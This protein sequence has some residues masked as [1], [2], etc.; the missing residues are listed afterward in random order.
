MSDV[1]TCRW[2]PLNSFDLDMT[3]AG[4]LAR[5]SNL[6]DNPLT[7][8][9]IARAQHRL[10]G[11]PTFY[12]VHVEGESRVNTLAQD[13]TSNSWTQA[14]EKRHLKEAASTSSTTDSNGIV[15]PLW[16]APS[17][18]PWIQSTDTSYTEQFD[19]NG[20]AT[21][22][23]VPLPTTFQEP[24]ISNMS[25]STTPSSNS[26]EVT[27]NSTTTT[28]STYEI[29]K[30][31]FFRLVAE[32]EGYYEKYLAKQLA[33]STSIFSRINNTL[34]GVAAGRSTGASGYTA[35]EVSVFSTRYL[36][37]HHPGFPFMITSFNATT[38]STTTTTPASSSGSSPVAAP[39]LANTSS[40]ATN[41]NVT[42]SSTVVGTTNGN[43]TNSSTVVGSSSTSTT[44]NTDTSNT[45][46]ST[47][48]SNSTGASNS[49]NTTTNSSGN[50]SSTRVIRIRRT[51]MTMS[52]SEKESEWIW[53]APP[54][55]QDVEVLPSRTLLQQEDNVRE[56]GYFSSTSALL[57]DLLRPPE[58]PELGVMTRSEGAASSLTKNEDADTTDAASR[59]L[60]SP[61][62][63]SVQ[64][65][66]RVWVFVC[67][68]ELSDS[69][70]DS[71]NLDLSAVW[72]VLIVIL[73][74][75]LIGACIVGI[76]GLGAAG[77]GACAVGYGITQCCKKIFGEDPPPRNNPGNNV[78]Y[79]NQGPPHFMPPGSM[80]GG[81]GAS[82]QYQQ[83][84]GEEDEAGYIN[85]QQQYNYNQNQYSQQH[86][87]LQPIGGS[88]SSASMM[89]TQPY[90][91]V[92][93]G[94]QYQLQQQGYNSGFQEG[95]ASKNSC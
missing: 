72:V 15:V 94:N 91:G 11:S 60:S 45:T 73:I 50:G 81:G 38:I 31:L 10:R 1:R 28:T 52:T 66:G 5:F 59:M 3:D 68:R 89:Q 20:Y 35:A 75:L 23:Q 37:H 79:Y 84:L 61:S 21:G 36:E 56:R 67:A 49:S 19:A 18:E 54:G 77:G 85:Q 2:V 51:S 92:A 88:S 22:R 17:T 74:L 83:F 12:G 55:Q 48:N 46:N 32:L 78:Q 53:D 76:A 71:E 29:E 14:I 7:T 62:L 47:I 9:T 64:L 39:A 26:N 27:D 65:R 4:N 70:G 33:E 95:Q 13:S 16:L 24:V 69:S 6:V 93:I 44:N 42:N 80:I 63:S 40:N 8:R 25:S 34:P 90:K 41:G 86:Q 58:E 57:E 87:Q 30:T 82:K 43:V